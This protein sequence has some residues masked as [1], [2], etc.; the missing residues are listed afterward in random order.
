MGLGKLGVGGGRGAGETAD[1]GESVWKEEAFVVWKLQGS[2][3]PAS[4]TKAG[5]STS[6]HSPT[7]SPCKQPRQPFLGL[8]S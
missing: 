4:K 6:L 1:G 8:W 2:P 7:Y 5:L 3:A